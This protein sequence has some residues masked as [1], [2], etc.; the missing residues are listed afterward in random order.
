M[1]KK[2][3]LE[4]SPDKVNT[5]IGKETFFKGVLNGKGLIR[6]DGE[7]EGTIINKGDVT[8]GESGKVSVELKARN[9]TIAG[10]YEGD[11]T[12]EGKLELKR[13]ATAI[14]TFKSNGLLVEDGAVISGS[15]DMKYKDKPEA[16]KQ[17]KDWGFK[18]A[19]S[20]QKEKSQGKRPFSESLMS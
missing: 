12:A 19:D 6:I 9:V 8:I 4:T 17:K 10:H 16:E 2:D 11:L 20:E 18:H 3:N 7:A 14:G 15:M 1:F 5:V 13:T